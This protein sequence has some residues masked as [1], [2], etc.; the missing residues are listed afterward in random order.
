MTL[1][2]RQGA[3]ELSKWQ[4]RRTFA[5]DSGLA[6]EW[7]TMLASFS[8][9]LRSD[10]VISFTKTMGEAVAQLTSFVRV[11]TDITTFWS[12]SSLGKVYKW[13][14]DD[15]SGTQ[16]KQMVP[17]ALGD[18]RAPIADLLATGKSAMTNP[19]SPLVGFIWEGLK[20]LKDTV[21]GFAGTT[22]G[23][24]S[25]ESR[26]LSFLQSK[27][28]SGE[29]SQ[30]DVELYNK[31][32]EKTTGALPVQKMP[33]PV[34][35]ATVGMGNKELTSADNPALVYG[36]AAEYSVRIQNQQNSIQSGILGATERT[37]VATEEI[38]RTLRRDSI[39][40]PQINMPLTNGP[41][42]LHSAIPEF[43]IAM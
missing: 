21:Q 37:A 22:N 17:E 4:L 15:T 32:L 36:T 20:G 28:N 31:L 30:V 6:S 34:D 42:R 10:T 9:L 5:E 8:D 25:D 7:K 2:G 27:M 41:L 1:Q 19:F 38:Q 3:L 16:L 40:A 26:S 13:L 33:S 43:N 14:S 39:S 35:M 29:A 18:A 24:T 11:L 12:N 23:L